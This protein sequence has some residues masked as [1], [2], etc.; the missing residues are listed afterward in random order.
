[1]TLQEFKAFLAY[2]PE[3]GVLI[4][5]ATG[6]EAGY[7]QSKG[8]LAVSIKNKR[9]LVHRVIWFMTHG[10]WPEQI[11]HINGDKADNR[12]SNLRAATN[13]QNHWNMD[14]QSNNLLGLKGVCFHKRARKYMASITVNRKFKYLGLFETKE[15]AHAAASAARRALHE[16]FYRGEGT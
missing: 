15:D 1:M 10:E 16:E 4:R 7:K 8:Y 14:V 12:L 3:T 2:D 11:D 6:D 5:K 9:Y 13:R